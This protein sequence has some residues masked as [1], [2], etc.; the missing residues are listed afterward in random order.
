MVIAAAVATAAAGRW[1]CGYCVFICFI[2]YVVPFLCR[3]VWQQSLNK[4][5]VDGVESQ[6]KSQSFCSKEANKY[7]KN[8][9]FGMLFKGTALFSLYFC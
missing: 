8:V 7:R 6:K 9:Y 3:A 5:L 1:V 4:T 2:V